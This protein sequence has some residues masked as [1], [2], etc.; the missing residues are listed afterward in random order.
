MAPI[1]QYNFDKPGPGVN[2]GEPRKTGYRRF[3]ELL[4]LS[5]WSFFKAGILACISFLP[6]YFGLAMAVITHLFPLMLLSGILGGA[7]VGPQITGIADTILRAQRDEP[8]MWWLTYKAA[9][10]RNWKASLLP[11]ALAGFLAASLVFMLTHL[12]PEFLSIPVMLGM[13]ISALVSLAMFTYL[14]P[15]IALFDM[16][17]GQILRNAL[18]LTLRHPLRTLAAA[19]AQL[20]YWGLFLAYYPLTQI[21]LPITGL[22]FPLFMGLSIVYTPMEADFDLENRVKEKQEARFRSDKV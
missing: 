1:F 14:I 16:G 13:L 4:S 10:K 9:W 6:F 11:G 19:A 17:L 5:G 3:A 2:P 8:G 15:Q 22:W 21:M 12:N 18:L 20:L 7:I